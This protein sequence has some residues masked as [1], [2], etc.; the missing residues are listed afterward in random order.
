MNAP[1]QRIPAT[2]LAV[3]TIFPLFAA[4]L[5][6]PATTP[7]PSGPASP[8]AVW[9]QEYGG[10]HDQRMQW[11]REARFGMFI[12]WG[13]YAQDGCFWKGQDGKSEHMMRHLKSPIAEYEKIA[14]DFNPV[15]FDADEWVRIAKAVGMKYLIITS[16]HRDGF[17]MYDS[18]SDG[19]NIVA[20]APFKRDPI[21]ELAEACRTQGLWFGVYYSLGRDWHDPD[22]PTRDG[23]RSNT[24]DFPDESE[25]D[26]AKYFERKVKPQVRELLTQYG[27]IAVLWFDTPEKISKAQSQELVNLVHRLQPACTINARVGNR[28]GD[29]AVQEQKIPGTGDPKPWETCRTLN[30]HWGYHKMDQSWKSTETLVRHLIEVASKGGNFLL[31]VGPTGEGLIPGPSVAHLKEVGEWMKVNG[32]AIYGTTASPFKRPLAWGWSTKK[33][34]AAGTTLYLHVFDWPQDGKLLL[35]GMKNRVTSATLLAGAKE[36]TTSNG[37]DGLV[38][39]VPGVAPDK[40]SSTVAVTLHGSLQTE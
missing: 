16:K 8:E 19:Y 18:K 21:K 20:R 28:L 40:I 9:Q 1:I 29:Y 35:P 2:A 27:P 13:L 24:W 3:F 30:G 32:E 36:L 10:T 4:E 25:K 7:T 33:S 11:W 23:Y 17:A 37:P 15:K 39:N 5:P 26:F 34:T 22:V 38:I 31:N 12:H 14:T 6:E